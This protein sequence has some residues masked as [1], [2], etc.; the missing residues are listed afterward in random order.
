MPSMLL[1]SKDVQDIS[2]RDEPISNDFITWLSVKGCCFVVHHRDRLHNNRPQINDTTTTNVQWQSEATTWQLLHQPRLETKWRCF[3]REIGNTDQLC[4]IAAWRLTFS[5]TWCTCNTQSIPATR[6]GQ[7]LPYWWIDVYPHRRAFRETT[8]IIII[9]TEGK[10]QWMPWSAHEL[11]P[12][13]NQ[14][15]RK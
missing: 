6:L 3:V 7:I 8:A 5:T 12:P 15:T 14:K 13:G 1:A 2:Q 4:I 9:P 11:G 10:Q